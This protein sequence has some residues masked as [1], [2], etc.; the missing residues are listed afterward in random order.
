MK[1]TRTLILIPLLL[2][3]AVFAADLQPQGIVKKRSDANSE[4]L[5]RRR[6][7]DLARIEKIKRDLGAFK[8]EIN[9][10]LGPDSTTRIDDPVD[11]DK[12]DDISRLDHSHREDLDSPVRGRI[13]SRYGYRIHPVS[14]RRGSFHA[15]LDIAAKEGTPVRA[16]ADGTVA[17]AAYLKNGY[18]KL[19]IIEH[20][21]DLATWY[22]HLSA[23]GVTAGQRV[24]RGDIIGAVGRTGSA[25]GPHLHFEVR[26]GG[27]ALDPEAFLP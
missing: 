21:K 15:G 17:K 10:L 26:R 19:V 27:T 13:T 6:A 7:S 5:A 9:E 11:V 20:E 8:D 23:I 16:S 4:T 18:G 24:L 1:N 12:I 2:L 25:T 22:G 14:K 3:A